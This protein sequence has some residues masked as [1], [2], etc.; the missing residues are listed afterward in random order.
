MIISDGHKSASIP[1]L[2]FWTCILDNFIMNEH[3]NSLV[4]IYNQM[5]ISELLFCEKILLKMAMQC[6]GWNIIDDW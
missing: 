2:I 5:G 3:Y 4:I 6:S 1:Q